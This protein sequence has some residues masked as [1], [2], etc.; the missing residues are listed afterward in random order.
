MARSGNHHPKC[1]FEKGNKAAVGHGPWKKSSIRS[2]N[3]KIKE[4][5]DLLESDPDALEE[6]LGVKV[7]KNM[8]KRDCQLLLVYNEI[9]KALQGSLQHSTE[10]KRWLEGDPLQRHE[11]ETKGKSLV[12]LIQEGHAKVKNDEAEK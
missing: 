1:K 10:I 7:P 4:I 11:V 5:F 2:W 6:R 9:V 8:K 12:Q 3:T